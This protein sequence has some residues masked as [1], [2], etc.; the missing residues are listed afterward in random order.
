MSPD[1]FLRDQAGVRAIDRAYAGDYLMD[2]GNSG[3][4]RACVAH[5]VALAANGGFDGVFF[6]DVTARLSFELGPGHHGPRVSRRR[7]LAAGDACDDR[8][9]G[10]RGASRRQARGGRPRRRVMS[11]PGQWQQWNGPLDGAE[12][13]VVG[14]RNG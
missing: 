2:V 5:A 1:W 8:L 7:G 9:R 3:Y 12:G 4:Q 11:T 10:P 6:D 14:R 13:G